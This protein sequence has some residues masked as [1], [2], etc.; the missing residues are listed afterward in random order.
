MEIITTTYKHCDLFKVKGRIDSSTA[1]QLSEALTAAVEHGHHKIVLDFSELEF[2]SSAG[3][4]V[5]ISTQKICKRY[6]RGEV[7][8][9][10]IPPNIYSALDLAGFTL[11][12]KIFDDDVTAVGS[13]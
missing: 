11:F 9:A 4:R 8:L 13:F 1:P 6:N 10:S 3:L 7:V 12:F 5:M 2:I